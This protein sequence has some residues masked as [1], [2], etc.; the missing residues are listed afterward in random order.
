M[1]RTLDV[2]AIL[3]EIFRVYRDEFGRITAIVV[4][5]L[6]PVV[7][8]QSIALFLEPF[9][10]MMLT[11]AAL[12]PSI[13]LQQLAAAALVHLT[14]D[15]LRGRRTTVG[16]SFRTALQ[17][18]LPVLAVALIVGLIMLAGFFL[19]LVPGLIAM[20]CLYVAIPVAVLE[21]RS[22][23]ESLRRSLDMTAGRRWPVFW[24]VLVLLSIG[25]G[26]AV[27]GAALT[28]GVDEVVGGFAQIALSLVTTG[29]GGVAQCVVYDRLR[30]LDGDADDLAA[31]FA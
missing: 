16:R 25:L 5:A 8:M 26:V 3:S 22:I 7:I 14:Y 18:L 19:L 27:V 15:R 13:V 1:A 9:E 6:S 20:V 30:R 21:R 2:G 29:I 17:R 28:L 24:I 31:V 10:K 12:L 23:V 4:V 11:F